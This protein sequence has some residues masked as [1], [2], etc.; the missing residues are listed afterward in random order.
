MD[1]NDNDIREVQNA[2][3]TIKGNAL[4]CQNSIFSIHNIVSLTFDSVA[5]E[6]TE[7]SDYSCKC[8]EFTIASQW[9]ALWFYFL[10]KFLYWIAHFSIIEEVTH[11]VNSYIN[12]FGNFATIS[13]LFL[14][15]FSIFFF[16]LYA[17]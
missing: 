2:L 3:V 17:I 6:I 7:Q 4:R 8:I 12:I 13:L 15:L 16:I 1:S 9:F 5:K 14:L 11:F 10:D